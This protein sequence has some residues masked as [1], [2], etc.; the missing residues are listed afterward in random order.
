MFP[1]YTEKKGE[2][3]RLYPQALVPDITL[4][5]ECLPK[6]SGDTHKYRVGYLQVLAGSKSYPGAVSLCCKAAAKVGA[7]GVKAIVPE[8]IWPIIAAKFDELMLQ[9]IKGT[10]EGALSKEALPLI[11][12]RCH[13]ALIGCGLGRSE[14]TQ[15]M[16]L[17]FLETWDKNVVVDADA[18]YALGLDSTLLRKGTS[19]GRWLLTPHVG[20]FSHLLGDRQLHK[21]SL[22]NKLIECAISWKVVILL[23]GFPAFIACPDGSLYVNPTG[24]PAAATAGC[25]DVLAG[26]CAG[27]LAQGLLPSQAALLG[28]YLAGVISDHYVATTGAYSLIATDI[29]AG[30]SHVIGD[31]LGNETDFCPRFD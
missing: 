14:E 10:E 26:M 9:S 22:L 5:Q 4:I 23:K 7:G 8:P 3:E 15:K 2:L 20:E 1:H 13:A 21:S 17:N 16:V 18:L 30:I 24:N 28:I 6:R 12:H 11:D 31:F 25:G 29:I 27:F 19:Q